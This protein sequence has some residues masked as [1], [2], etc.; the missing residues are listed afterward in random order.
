[1]QLSGLSAQIYTPDNFLGELAR[2]SIASEV[3]R[4]ISLRKAQAGEREAAT[5]A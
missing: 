2:S 3:L 5:G 1:M 4:S